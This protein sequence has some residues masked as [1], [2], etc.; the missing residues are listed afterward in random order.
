M[1]MPKKVNLKSFR[2]DEDFQRQV[3]K[4]HWAQKA[5]PKTIIKL[6]C[7]HMSIELEHA[8]D[9]FLSC[10]QCGHKWLYT[11]SIVNKRLYGDG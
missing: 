10:P 9:Q 6:P 5:Q 11:H 4:E 2:L 8:E 1:P 7:G 3:M